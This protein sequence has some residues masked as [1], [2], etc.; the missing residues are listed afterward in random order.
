MNA[1][2]GLVFDLAGDID[3]A[4]L[5]AT[6]ALEGTPIRVEQWNHEASWD[7]I[8]HYALG[9]GDDNPLFCD[10]AYGAATPYGCL[11]AP[12]TFLYTAFDGAVGAGMPGVQPI[13]AGT[14]WRFHRRVRRNDGITASA[15]FGPV[16]RVSGG[17]ATD[18]VIQSA[19]CRYE[20]HEGHLVAEADARTFRVPR[21]RTSNGLSYQPRETHEYADGELDAIRDEAVTEFRRGSG[22]LTGVSPGDVVPTVVK[23]PIG[24]IDMTAYYAGCP[25]SPGYKSVEMAWKY[26]KW[27]FTD[28]E[29]LPSNYDPS[30]FGERVLPSI[31][32]QDATAARELGMPGAYN[33]GPQRVGWFAHCLTNWMGDGAF[34]AALDVRLRRPEIFGDVIRIGGTVTAVDRAGECQRVHVA[35][36]AKNQFGE[37]T[38]D[39][40]AEVLLDEYGRLSSDGKRE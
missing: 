37:R 2:T 38:A 25:G 26:R 39:G 30:Y 8:R 27:A 15:Q 19:L 13:Y 12:P 36:E 20:D 11:L 40:V 23:G 35:L 4:G 5:A 1:G 7:S 16:R 21:R 10:A 24:R 29:R 34:L 28:T 33:N 22:D 18:M 17:T 3:A 14:S 6:E 9:L 31:G 32:H